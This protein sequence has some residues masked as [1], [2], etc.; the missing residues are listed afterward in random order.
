LPG[1][2]AVL[3]GL[4]GWTPA[5]TAAITSANACAALPRLQGLQTLQGQSGL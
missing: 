3:A 2:A 4:R 1:I 5:Q